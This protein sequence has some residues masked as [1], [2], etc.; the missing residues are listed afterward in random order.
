MNIERKQTIVVKVGGS[1]LGSGDTTYADISRLQ[2]GGYNIVVVHGGGKVITEW[3]KKQ[4]AGTRF[5]RGQR[6]TDEDTLQVVVAVLAGLVNK[7]IVRAINNSGG[8]AAGICGADGEILEAEI[9]SAELGLVGEIT[10]VNTGLIKGLLQQGYVPVIAPVGYLKSGGQLLN[11]NADNAAAAISVALRADKL[12]FLTDVPGVLDANG[13]LMTKLN[14]TEAR[15]LINSSAV[16]GGMIPKLEA[17]LSAVKSVPEARIIDG[18]MP[19]A[20][21][22]EVAGKLAGTTIII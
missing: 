6:V 3:L 14:S 21:I 5:V 20:L 15:G 9:K 10:R 22:S 11:I 2:Q 8:R 17:C 1:T 19:G 16:S 4:G 18:R 13:S 7:D 12:I